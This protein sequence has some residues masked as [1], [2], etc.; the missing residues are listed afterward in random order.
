VTVDEL[1]LLLTSP[2][3]GDADVRERERAFAALLSRPDEA[4]A[5]ALEALEN[6][7]LSV[8]GLA[9]LLARLGRPESVPALARLLDSPFE[10]VRRAGADALAAHPAAS[11]GEALVRA[12]DKGT[13]EAAEAL[14]AG[15]EP[16]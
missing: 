3:G 4:H 16:G 2:G 9:P 12:R 6:G 15:S 10:T 8:V 14:D 11:A 7:D 13:A 1:L 5:R